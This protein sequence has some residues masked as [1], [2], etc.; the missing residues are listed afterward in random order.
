MRNKFLTFIFLIF[1]STAFAQI[2]VPDNFEF[3]LED[4]SVI[5]GGDNLKSVF[6][7]SVAGYFDPSYSG[8]KDRLSNF[9][10]YKPVSGFPVV[11]TSSPATSITSSSA[12]LGGN[13]TSIGSSPVTLRGIQYTS[14]PESESYTQV[15]VGS[16]IGS[17]S[18]NVTGLS[19][20]TRYYYRAFAINSSGASYGYLFEFTT[21]Y[22]VPDPPSVLSVS[23]VN[24]NETTTNLVGYVDPNIGGAITER[25][26]VYNLTSAADPTTSSYL[27]KLVYVGDASIF[28]SNATGLTASTDYKWRAYAIN[29]AGTG[30]GE[31]KTFKTNSSG[32]TGSCPVVGDEYQGGIVAY[33]AQFGQIGYVEGECHG[34]IISKTNLGITATVPWGL[35]PNRITGGDSFLYNGS[36]YNT[37]KI[38]SAYGDGYYA[39]KLC[40]DY[41]SDG[42]DDWQ[43]P[44]QNAL[45]LVITLPGLT[46]GTYWTSTDNSLNVARTV[47]TDLINGSSDKSG[48]SHYV[49]AIRYF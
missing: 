44:T 22:L 21:S 29:A 33:V 46:P 31:I 36:K 39:A 45:R 27:G 48:N 16:G 13:V 41:V 32:S 30:Y 4:V 40:S 34:L 24:V 38:V 17:F 14:S 8:L 11:I 10:N 25:G 23:S 20:A 42:Y 19:D 49:R 15:N 43:L 47:N 35:V 37:D 28:S 18:T 12:T 6:N 2:G 5:V 3:T 9:R 26:F 1:S 7:N